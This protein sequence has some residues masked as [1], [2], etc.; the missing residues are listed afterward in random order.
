MLGKPGR[1]IYLVHQSTSLKILHAWLIYS[2]TFFFILR[3][4]QQNM[5]QEPQ[6]LMWGEVAGIQNYL[7]TLGI[8]GDFLKQ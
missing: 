1:F 2:H 5:D 3:C 8:C 4:G 6:H 7:G